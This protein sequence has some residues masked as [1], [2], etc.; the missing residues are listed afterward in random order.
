MCSHSIQKLV[1]WF[2]MGAYWRCKKEKHTFVSRFMLEICQ[3]KTKKK[4]LFLNCL[5]RSWH[6]HI[7]SHNGTKSHTS[8]IIG[9]I[10]V[11]AKC[12]VKQWT[13]DGVRGTHPL[14]CLK[15]QQRRFCSMAVVGKRT[16]CTS[17]PLHAHALL[18]P[19]RHSTRQFFRSADLKWCVPHGDTL[20]LHAATACEK[21]II[22]LVGPHLRQKLIRTTTDHPIQAD[23]DCLVC[24]KPRCAISFPNC[25][26]AI[27]T[28]QI[29]HWSRLIYDE[30]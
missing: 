23:L 30:T 15:K 13:L 12:A 4:I 26:N 29:F 16:E 22:T 8:F 19:L 5:K 6:S 7:R 17:F 11:P 10:Q 2:E 18:T 3:L 28:E 21:K 1:T 14:V 27:N 25:L 20:A 24:Y 9:M